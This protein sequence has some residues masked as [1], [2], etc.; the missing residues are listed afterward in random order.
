[1]TQFQDD[2][3]VIG[4]TSKNP[5][6]DIFADL[7]DVILLDTG[8]TIKGTFANPDMVEGIKISKKPIGMTTNAGRKVMNLEGQIKNFGTVYVDSTQMANIFG[9]SHLADKH[10][11]TYDSEKEDAFFVHTD[12]GIINLTGPLMVSTPISPH[13][14]I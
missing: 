9:F 10:R 12:D 4:Q 6:H 2:E 7:K 11:I 3:I 5:N 8:S 13:K 14:A 1:M